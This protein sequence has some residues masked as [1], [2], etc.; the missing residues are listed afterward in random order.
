MLPGRVGDGDAESAQR[1]SAHRLDDPSLLSFETSGYLL[2]GADDAE[3]LAVRPVERRERVHPN[4]KQ[5]PHRLHG[6]VQDQTGVG[7]LARQTVGGGK[8]A[9]ETAWSVQ[10]D[11]GNRVG[12]ADIVRGN[13]IHQR[14]FRGQTVEFVVRC[15][16]FH[17]RRLQSTAFQRPASGLPLLLE[18]PA[19]PADHLVGPD[20]ALRPLEVVYLRAR[21]EIAH[22]L[23]VGPQCHALRVRRLRRHNRRDHHRECDIGLIELREELAAPLLPFRLR[24]TAGVHR[25]RAQRRDGQYDQRGERSA[26]SRRSAPPHV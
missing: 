3:Q 17:R 5:I 1:S 9:P 16:G 4:Q 19:I 22:H 21:G 18:I 8:D 23:G 15:G 14:Q 11:N 20:A 2:G 6:E 25:F 13:R 7:K 26:T 10:H 12:D 24:G